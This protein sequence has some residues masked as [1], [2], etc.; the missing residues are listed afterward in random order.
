MYMRGPTSEAYITMQYPKCNGDS[1]FI[2][3]ARF[4][5]QYINQS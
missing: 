1:I 4:G 2:Y 3:L 5:I